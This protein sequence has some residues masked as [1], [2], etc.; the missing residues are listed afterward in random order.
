M[1]VVAL[2]IDGTIKEYG[3]VLDRASISAL[4]KY[5]A[6][7]VVSSRADCCQV[8]ASYGI[9]TCLCAGVH[10]SDKADC[11]RKLSSIQQAQAGRIYI[12]DLPSDFEAA[13]AAGWNWADANSL[14]LNLGAGL[15]KIDGCVNVDVRPLPTV[16]LPI[17]I[18]DDWPFPDG[19][20]K[21]IYAYDI[22]EHV[23][24]RR[25]EVLWD[26]MRRKCAPGCR[27]T[28]RAPDMDLLYERVIKPR[29]KRGFPYL[30]QAFS[31]W[32]GGGQ[33]Y[34]ENT[35]LT[36]FTKDALLELARAFGFDGICGDDGGT[37]LLCELTKL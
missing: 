7:A 35:H 19:T 21:R 16:D 9:S 18:L 37:N 34:P 24:W 23:P 15:A 20:I 26:I 5:A 22:I 8:A 13:K 27:V 25:Q 2:D 36:F 14:C 33:D 4:G 32:V 11:L 3:G 29:D 30:Y 10:C 1:S 17:D 6:L 31:Y 12:A 28:V